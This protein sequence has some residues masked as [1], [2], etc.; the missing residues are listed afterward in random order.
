MGTDRDAQ[1]KVLVSRLTSQPPITL[2]HMELLKIFALEDSDYGNSRGD[3][4][5]REGVLTNSGEPSVVSTSTIAALKL[6]L[7]V[8]AAIAYSH[9]LVGTGFELRETTGEHSFFL[10]IDDPDLQETYGGRIRSVKA[11]PH[12]SVITTDNGC[13][14]YDPSPMFANGKVLVLHQTVAARRLEAERKAGAS[15]E[16]I[17]RIR[18]AYALATILR[19]DACTVEECKKCD[20]GVVCRTKYGDMC[21]AESV[22]ADYGGSCVP[23]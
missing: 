17:T 14:A 12:R 20:G 10:H 2:T 5:L 4:V 16:R 1:L 21:L 18:R 19:G 6:A 22:C 11:L 15:S 8:P 13:I 23:K 9:E 7:N 3:T